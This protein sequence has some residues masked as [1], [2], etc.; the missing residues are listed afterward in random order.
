MA[1]LIIQGFS[2]T[3]PVVTLTA[4]SLVKKHGDRWVIR[5]D[6][7]A[8]V[9]DPNAVRALLDEIKPALADKPLKSCK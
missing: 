6:T 7:D 3:I 2:V 5:A 8:L 1:D 4:I 9:W